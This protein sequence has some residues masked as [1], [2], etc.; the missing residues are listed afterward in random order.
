MHDVAMTSMQTLGR[1]TNDFH[2]IVGL[3]FALKVDL[4]SML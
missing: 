2:V 1:L 3:Q 4:E